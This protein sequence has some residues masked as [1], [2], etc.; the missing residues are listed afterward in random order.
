MC[1]RVWGL[2]LRLLCA[3][4]GWSGEQLIK[5]CDFGE[6]TPELPSASGAPLSRSMLSTMGHQHGSKIY[7]PPEARCRPCS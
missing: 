1:V 3:H 6:C 4:T 2:Q 7:A 5:V